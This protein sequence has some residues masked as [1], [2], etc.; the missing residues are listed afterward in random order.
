MLLRSG[1]RPMISAD[2]FAIVL[3]QHHIEAPQLMQML[4][5][6]VA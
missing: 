3:L 6:L 4:E 5:H 2:R 1:Q